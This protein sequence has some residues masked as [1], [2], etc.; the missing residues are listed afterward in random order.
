MSATTKAK[1]PNLPSLLPQNISTCCRFWWKVVYFI[2]W[3][4]FICF[5][6]I[7]ATWLP[8]P[9]LWKFSFRT[10]LRCL[11][12]SAAAA[13]SNFQIFF[14]LLLEIHTFAAFWQHLSAKHSALDNSIAHKTL[15]S[16]Q[17]LLLNFW[18]CRWAHS[19]FLQRFHFLLYPSHHPVPWQLA[20]DIWCEEKVTFQLCWVFALSMLVSFSCFIRTLIFFLHNFLN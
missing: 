2:F 13:I 9:D 16:V 8:L 15:S 18:T 3:H 10:F 11:L 4:W 6:V 17:L 12:I 19:R 5:A 7:V 14:P 20:F 1:P